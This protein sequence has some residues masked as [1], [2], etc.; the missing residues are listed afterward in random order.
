[1]NAAIN[2]AHNLGWKLAHVLKGWAKPLL[3]NTVGVPTSSPNYYKLTVYPVRSGEKE[4][5][6]GSHCVRPKI[7]ITLLRKG[8][9]KTRG[10]RSY[11]RGVLCVS[12]VFINEVK[13]LTCDAVRIKVTG[14]LQVVSASST[15]TECSPIE[16]TRAFVPV[17]KL[18]NGYPSK[19]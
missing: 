1:M 19:R 9:V 18:G 3:I 10:R 7:C 16:N 2:D 8:S 5:C 6:P 12:L 4:V 15:P 17:L 14:A 11:S 13:Y